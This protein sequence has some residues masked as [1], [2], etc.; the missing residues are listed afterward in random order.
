MK[1]LSPFEAALSTTLAEAAPAI[2]KH[3]GQSSGVQYYRGTMQRVWRKHG[4]QSWAAWPFLKLGHHY[5]TLLDRTGNDVPFELEN[6]VTVLPDG[7]TSMTWKRIF[8]FVA[9]TECFN[10]CMVFAPERQRIIDFLGKTGHLEVELVAKIEHKSM[11]IESGRQWLW[12]KRVYQYLPNWRIPLP[13]WV[14]G[15]ATV[16]EWQNSDDTHG[17]SVTVNNP[18]LGDFFGYEGQ[19][20]LVFASEYAQAITKN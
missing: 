9:E 1:T 16:H 7:Q 12:L 6:V 18:I 8:H 17:I 20:K 3:F 2:A 5:D 11:L 19:F 15:R 14:T 13:I 10:A 4:W